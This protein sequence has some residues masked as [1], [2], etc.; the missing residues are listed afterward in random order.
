MNQIVSALSNDTWYSP[1]LSFSLSDDEPYQAKL[2]AWKYKLKNI[3]I[4]VTIQNYLCFWLYSCI[5]FNLA[6]CTVLQS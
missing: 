4:F 2:L 1:E 3:S 5:F 6:E